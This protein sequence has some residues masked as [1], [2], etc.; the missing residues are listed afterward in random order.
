MKPNSSISIVALAAALV[1]PGWAH[2][3]E[4]T[5]ADVGPEAATIVEDTEE[6]RPG[7]DL[8]N[9]QLTE[10]LRSILNVPSE[11][12]AAEAF[13]DGGHPYTTARA[14]SVGSSTPVSEYPWRAT[15]KLLMQ[16]G[17][18][19]FVCT[20]S[21]IELNLLVTAAHCV[22]EFGQGQDGFAD[23]VTFEPAR[24]EGDRPF[25]TWTG[26]TWYAPT[27]YVDGTDE[28]SVEAPGIVCE[29]DIA[30][31]VL[32]PN[33]NG[34]KIADVVGR[35][36]VVEFDEFGYAFFLGQRAAH[37]TQLGYP[38]ADFDGDKMIR[39]DS[40]GIWDDP[41]NVVWGSGQ[42]GGSSGGPQLQNFGAPTTA[43][44]SDPTDGT[45]NIVSSVTS[46]GF[47]NDRVK[48]QGASRFSTNTSF[49]TKSNIL[50]LI[51]AAC[52]DHPDACDGS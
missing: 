28:C 21:V 49:T 17:A 27:V 13:G 8:T 25:G 26:R 1:T 9:V 18:S 30:V 52:G 16:F 44:T 31:V 48:V 29:N 4:V 45:P 2:A 5:S 11:D 10:K 50:A 15:G 23:A 6:R 40:V 47:T 46:W 32:E 33:E 39:T 42:T 24:H 22:H 14:S 20:A 35:Y 51:E 19:N 36:K 37:L 43:A 7:R 34:E 12:S 41:N 38:S 3:N